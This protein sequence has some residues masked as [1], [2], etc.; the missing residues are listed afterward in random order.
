MKRP[1][2][3]AAIVFGL[4]AL[5]ACAGVALAQGGAPKPK[6]A[7]IEY[8]QRDVDATQI[9]ETLDDL[10]KSSWDVFQVMPVWHFSD[11]E[12]RPTRY[13]V[14]AKRKAAE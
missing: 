4:I 10:G 8:T 12:L 11:N 3:R 2:I 7:T 5:A 1:G 6:R 14:F 13:Q 9:V